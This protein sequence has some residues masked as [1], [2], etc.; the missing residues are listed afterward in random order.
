MV[1]EATQ[2]FCHV[3]TSPSG[4]NKSL[5][6]RWGTPHVINETHVQQHEQGKEALREDTTVLGSGVGESRGGIH[7]ASIQMN[8]S[9][10]VLLMWFLFC[11]QRLG[12]ITFAYQRGVFLLSTLFSGRCLNLL[13][14]T[15]R[16]L[17][18]P[19]QQQQQ[20]HRGAQVNASR[21]LSVYCV[22]DEFLA[23]ESTRLV[24]YVCTLCVSFN[25]FNSIKDPEAMKP[26]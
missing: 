11:M 21:H 8:N 18:V 14:G 6:G 16:A 17:L 3:G 5:L 2:S 25:R 9:A 19:T 12:S 20:R 22:S 7:P 15:Y 26:N 4:I 1:S 23:A 24:A 13:N 10:T